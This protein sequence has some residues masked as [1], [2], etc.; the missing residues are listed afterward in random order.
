MQ[1]NNLWAKEGWS[2][3]HLIWLMSDALKIYYENTMQRKQGDQI[4]WK[5]FKV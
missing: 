2:N 4:K 1:E 5:I 3:P